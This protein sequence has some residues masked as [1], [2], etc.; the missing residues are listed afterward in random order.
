MF[1]FIQ[2]QYTENFAF[3]ILRIIELLT[4]EVCEFLKK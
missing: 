1:V 2:K 4:R 3:F